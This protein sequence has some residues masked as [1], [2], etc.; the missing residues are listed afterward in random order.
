MVLLVFTAEANLELVDEQYSHQAEDLRKMALEQ[1][2]CLEFQS[3][4]EGDKEISLSY[5]PNQQTMSAWKEQADHLQAQQ[6]GRQRWYRH[7]R[8]V[9][10]A[11]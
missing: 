9:V 7:Y 8:V 11:V 4:T 1:Y 2:G 3:V 5:W 10:T 6:Q